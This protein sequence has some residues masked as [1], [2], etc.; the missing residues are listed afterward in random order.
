MCSYYIIDAWFRF[1]VKITVPEDS[2]RYTWHEMTFFSRWFSGRCA[3]LCIGATQWFQTLL[4]STL[5]ELGTAMPSS[6]PYAL[7]IPLI[8]AITA[9]QDSSVWL[10]RDIV[11]NVETVSMGEQ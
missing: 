8:E 11:R 3:I 5:A 2:S 1:I 9:M 7:H 6:E 10:V 4:W